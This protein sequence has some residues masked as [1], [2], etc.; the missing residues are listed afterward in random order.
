MEHVI[1][2]CRVRMSFCVRYQIQS[3]ARAGSPNWLHVYIFKERDL[4]ESMVRAAKGLGFSAV[5]VTVDHPTNFIVDT[6]LPHFIATP[7]LPVCARLLS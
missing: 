3:A 5:C 4:V 1:V 6:F 2:N 7:D